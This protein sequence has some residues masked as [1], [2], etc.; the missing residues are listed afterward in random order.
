MDLSELSL[1][2]SHSVVFLVCY[3]VIHIKSKS[4]FETNCYYNQGSVFSN[5]KVLHQLI[6]VGTVKTECHLVH[7]F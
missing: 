1:A 4:D 5:T 7:F 3:S 2:T 6:D